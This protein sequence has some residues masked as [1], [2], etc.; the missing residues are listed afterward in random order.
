M[1]E[2]LKKTFERH[3]NSAVQSNNVKT[4]ITTFKKTNEKTAG[5]DVRQGGRD[6]YL[7]A[8]YVLIGQVTATAINANSLWTVR[9]TGNE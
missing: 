1:K 2:R 5:T 7:N 6:Y 8:S 9:V 4:K 3:S